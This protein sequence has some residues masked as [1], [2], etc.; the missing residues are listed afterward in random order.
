[1]G[2]ISEIWRHFPSG[3]YEIKNITM[4]ISGIKVAEKCFQYF[5]K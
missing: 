1:M 4:V 5:G 3:I 2:F